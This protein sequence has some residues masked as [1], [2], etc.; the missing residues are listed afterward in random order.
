MEEALAAVD[1][2]GRNP[3]FCPKLA[4]G[5]SVTRAFRF[6]IEL[7]RQLITEAAREKISAN[8]LVT[9][10]LE[11]HLAAGAVR[12]KLGWME[13]PQML[14]ADLIKATQEEERNQIAR[15]RGI[16]LTKQILINLYGRA[17]ADTFLRCL[18]ELGKF[19]TSATVEV[20]ANREEYTILVLHTGAGTGLSKFISS[21]ILASIEY[22]LHVK[23]VVEHSE[24]ACSIK[25]KPPKLDPH[26][27]LAS[28]APSE[29]DQQVRLPLVRGKLTS[30]SASATV[31]STSN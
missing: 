10:M 21:M 14:W 3:S 23:G 28:I 15:S 1:A 18:P 26:S 30:S 4:K 7:E 13:F 8:R 9:R 12:K 11:D 31:N 5:R 16:E 6:P 20:T 29:S 19:L 17:A 22:F 2:S 25:F 24:I 27:R